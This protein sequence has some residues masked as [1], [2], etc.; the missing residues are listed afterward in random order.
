[1]TLGPQILNYGLRVKVMLIILPIPM[2]LKMRFPVGLKIDA[3]LC[4]V[5]KSTIQSSLKQIFRTSDTC[6][7][8]WEQAKKV[9]TP[10]SLKIGKLKE[11]SSTKTP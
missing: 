2:L 5:I 11:H 7:K 4:I 6:S 10:H 8:V 1:M 9:L 3:Q